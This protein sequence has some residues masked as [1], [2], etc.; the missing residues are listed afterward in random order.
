MIGA[1]E[2]NKGRCPICGGRLVTDQKATI[3]FV[4][5]NAVVII[6]DVPAEVCASCHES[7]TSGNV[8]DR[9]VELLQ[10]LRSLQTEVSVISY[11]S[12][13]VAV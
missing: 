7:Y 13:L 10:E 2:D 4:F 6:K 8:T 3:P 5:E 11:T 9:I 12:T 1:H